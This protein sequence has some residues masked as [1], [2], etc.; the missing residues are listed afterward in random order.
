MSP[1]IQIVLQLEK[2][3]K[4]A[5]AQELL[6]EEVDRLYKEGD[7]EGIDDLLQTSPARLGLG[8]SLALLI[9]TWAFQDRLRFYDMFLNRAREFAMLTGDEV[10]EDRLLHL[11]HDKPSGRFTTG[12]RRRKTLTP[13]RHKELLFSHQ[14]EKFEQV[15]RL[16]WDWLPIV[17]KVKSEVPDT[18]FDYNVVYFTT[19]EMI[20][21]LLRSMRRPIDV[22]DE[23]EQGLPQTEPDEI[24]DEIEAVL[25]QLY[26][27]AFE[28]PPREDGRPHWQLDQIARNWLERG[29]GYE[30]Q[31]NAQ[32]DVLVAPEDR[33]L[34]AYLTAAF[35]CATEITL[36]AYHN[37]DMATMTNDAA[38]G[39][40]IREFLAGT[41]YE[42]GTEVAVE[43]IELWYGRIKARLVNPELPG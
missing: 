40:M 35:T 4:L 26:E 43:V 27:I 28:Q 20:V 18:F 25:P 17:T 34:A 29:L 41:E 42:F 24:A 19:L 33:P 1:V 7:F 12:A 32:G 2:N 14:P 13:W 37:R 22:P 15:Q 11:E 3:G 39:S 6:L 38:L 36:W 21:D 16:N 9:F 8:L 10:A 30:H 5:D 23:G 31:T